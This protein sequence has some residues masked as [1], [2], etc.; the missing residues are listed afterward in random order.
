MEQDAVHLLNLAASYRFSDN[1]TASLNI[2]NLLDKDYYSRMGF[3]NGVHWGEPRNVTL[4]LR[5]RL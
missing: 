2:N 3:Y 4:N 1:I 5:I